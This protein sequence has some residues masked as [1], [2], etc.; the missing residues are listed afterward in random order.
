MLRRQRKKESAES[1]GARPATA[2][3]PSPAAPPAELPLVDWIAQTNCLRA[4]ITSKSFRLSRALQP[5]CRAKSLFDQIGFQRG[6]STWRFNGLRMTTMI[7]GLIARAL[8][9][10]DHKVIVRAA[11]SSL[12]QWPL[13]NCVLTRCLLHSRSTATA[14]PCRLACSANVSLI[15]FFER[16]LTLLI[17]PANW[18]C[19][20]QAQATACR[21]LVVT[22]RS[23]NRRTR[24]T[25]ERAR[26]SR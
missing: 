15:R 11:S 21:S 19:L 13:N 25:T 2:I 5:L 23:A 20:G 14:L 26:A 12:Q 7:R 10:P 17:P 6:F 16:C 24:A 4:A 8:G 18:C 22:A 3:R 1:T 9:T